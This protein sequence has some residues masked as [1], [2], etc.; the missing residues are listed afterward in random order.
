MSKAKQSATLTPNSLTLLTIAQQ[1]GPGFK[2]TDQIHLHPTPLWNY[3]RNYAD[4]TNDLER[5]QPILALRQGEELRVEFVELAK[6]LPDGLVVRR[7]SSNPIIFAPSD[8]REE[9]DVNNANL[10]SDDPSSNIRLLTTDDLK[11]IDNLIIAELERRGSR[12]FHATTVIEMP[13]T[14][15]TLHTDN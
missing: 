11:L 15:F 1:L 4:I 7:A 13:F 12:P 14:T 2:V 9:L 10:G 5:F 3:L 6:I 8:S